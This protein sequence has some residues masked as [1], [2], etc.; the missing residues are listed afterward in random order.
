[1][2]GDILRVA[3]IY[4]YAKTMRKMPFHIKM[5]PELIYEHLNGALVDKPLA[6]IAMNPCIDLGIVGP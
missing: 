4:M 2:P 6:R 5:R 3:I 1:M